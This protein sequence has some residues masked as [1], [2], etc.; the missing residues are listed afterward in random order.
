LKFRDKKNKKIKNLKFLRIIGIFNFLG[1]NH[2][3]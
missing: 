3:Y 2:K 1:W